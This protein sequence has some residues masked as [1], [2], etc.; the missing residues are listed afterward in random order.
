MSDRPFHACFEAKIRSISRLTIKISQTSFRVVLER[1]GSETRFQGDENSGFHK[2]F[3]RLSKIL[4]RDTY[5]C[6]DEPIERAKARQLQNLQSMALPGARGIRRMIEPRRV[7]P[8]SAR[9]NEK[10]FWY[11]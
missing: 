11:A 3:N 8:Q 10:A 1:R 7:D 4:C 9:G 5:L 6:R 2:F